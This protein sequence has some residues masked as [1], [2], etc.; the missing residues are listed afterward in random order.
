MCKKKTSSNGSA[1]KFKSST[2]KASDIKFNKDGSVNK[3]SR[4]VKNNSIKFTNSGNVD[5]RC[6]AYR[7]N[8]SLRVILFNDL[9]ITCLIYISFLFNLI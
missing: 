8:K 1:A 4:A 7:Q 6:T 2:V 9:N 3:N 5:K